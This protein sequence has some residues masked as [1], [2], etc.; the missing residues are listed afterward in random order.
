MTHQCRRPL[1]C[2]APTTAIHPMY[3]STI[4]VIVDINDNRHSSYSLLDPKGYRPPSYILSTAS[5]LIATQQ[6]VNDG[7]PVAVSVVEIFLLYF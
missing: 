2:K 3:P 1:H 7:F 6:G 4:N 5:Y